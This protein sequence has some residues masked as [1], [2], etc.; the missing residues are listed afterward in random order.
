MFVLSVA[1]SQTGYVNDLI[2]DLNKDHKGTFQ[3]TVII[4]ITFSGLKCN[5]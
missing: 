1:K 2:H 4:L 3:T 5:L